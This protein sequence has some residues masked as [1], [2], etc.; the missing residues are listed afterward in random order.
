MAETAGYRACRRCR[1]ESAAGVDQASDRVRRACDAVARQPDVPWTTARMA[2][3]GATSVAQ[4][5]RGFRDVLGLSP[6]DYVAACR[7]KSFLARLKG[8]RTVTDAIYASGFGSPSRVYGSFTLPGMTPATYGR[9]G[10]GAHIRWATSPSPIGRILV[11]ATDRGVCF[12]EVGPDEAALRAELARE[13]PSAELDPRPSSTLKPHMA[14]ARA[15]AEAKP[16]RTSVPVDI[17]GTAFQ[18]R[19][20]RAL[21]RIPAG[22]KRT[23]SDVARAIARPRSVRAVG[24]ACATNPLS[25]LV[26]CHRVVGRDDAVTG[27]RWGTDV[28]STLLA[29]EA[30]GVNVARGR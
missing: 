29:K 6:R 2:K 19:V 20:W 8:G 4:L 22:E 11:A 10:A 27:Y 17:R 26:P 9:G 5:Q 13:F 3:A 15:V 25:L 21:T 16:V 12:V 1:P 24:R 18:W 28:K 23:Y 14:L 7:R 30:R